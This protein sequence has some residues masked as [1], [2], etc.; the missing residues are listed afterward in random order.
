MRE[1]F[2]LHGGKAYSHQSSQTVRDESDLIGR[3]F[4]SAEI[5]YDEKI[6]SNIICLELEEENITI[7][8]WTEKKDCKLGKKKHKSNFSKQCSLAEIR[9]RLDST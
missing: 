9:R 1:K 5:N 4:V 2:D 7:I 8:P 6:D 3:I